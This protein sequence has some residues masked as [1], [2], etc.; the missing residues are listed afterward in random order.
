[1]KDPTETTPDGAPKVALGV[2]L[3][4]VG[5]A[6]AGSALVDGSDPL[7]GVVDMPR[8]CR[9]HLAGTLPV[10]L[11]DPC[12]HRPDRPGR[13]AA[14][15]RN[16]C[17]GREI[18]P[19]PAPGPAGP[20]GRV[21]TAR[22]RV[23]RSARAGRVVRPAGACTV[24]IPPRNSPPP[25]TERVQMN[26][27]RHGHRSRGI[28]CSAGPRPPCARPVPPTTPWPAPRTP[29]RRPPR[30]WCRPRSWRSS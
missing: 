8:T 9:H 14:D 25:A 26:A 1:M 4:R 30:E 11:A 23:A 19:W 20:D 27:L 18:R 17:A 5:S 12:P 22:W 7:T 16:R 28:G 6:V 10:D 15:H 21:G 13:R 29:R 2:Q 24:R 3:V